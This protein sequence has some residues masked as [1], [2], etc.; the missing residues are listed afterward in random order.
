[1]LEF[2]N[3]EEQKYLEDIIERCEGIR[4]VMIDKYA[5]KNQQYLD[6]IKNE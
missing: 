4:K 3:K 2:G 5:Q 6:Q 1:M